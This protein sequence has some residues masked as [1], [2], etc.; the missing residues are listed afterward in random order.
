MAKWFCG[1]DGSRTKL[2]R[3]N[4]SWEEEGVFGEENGEGEIL[5][6]PDWPGR[7]R[8]QELPEMRKEASP[9]QMRARGV[10]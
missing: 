6:V 7:W 3:V 1:G 5:E 8:R 9:G 10:P 2:S 4:G